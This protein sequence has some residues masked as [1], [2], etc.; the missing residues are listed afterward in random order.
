MLHVEREGRRAE[1]R[2]RTRCR[3]TLPYEGP[4]D[5]G[6]FTTSDEL[7]ELYAKRERYQR[8]VD[9]AIEY[10][11]SKTYIEYVEG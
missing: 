2:R 11:E 4:P 3:N 10:R 9:N 1:R 7:A 8:R 5:P 6:W